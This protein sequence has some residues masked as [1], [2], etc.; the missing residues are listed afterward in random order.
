LKDKLADLP[1]ETHVDAAGNFWTTLRGESPDALVM[2][3]HMDSVPNGG[4]LDG[5][6]N[7]MAGVEVLRRI[8]AE[9][10][11]R[12]PITVRVVDWADEE[13]AR[14]G[15]S[16]FGS[17][18]CAGSLVMEEARGLSELAKTGWKPKRSI[19]Y[20]SWDAEE[21]GLIGST[22]WVETHADE[23]R[24]KAAVYINTDNTGRGFLGIG[25]SHTLEKFVNE[26]GKDGFELRLPG[27]DR[28]EDAGVVPGAIGR[29]AVARDRHR[30]ILPCLRFGVGSRFE[31]CISRAR[32][33]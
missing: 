32:M 22:E 27:L 25:G 4:W 13:G 14:F 12:P 23:L 2:G 19:I 3:G 9:Y 17:S 21:E 1:V 31:R 20:A 24:Q 18:A 15:K 8:N 16:L 26:V 6:L 33:R 28:R 10:K 30:G 7:V 29:N 11:G 5:C